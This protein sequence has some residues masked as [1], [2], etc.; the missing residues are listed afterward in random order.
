MANAGQA[1]HSI[2]SSSAIIALASFC[3]T[4][5]AMARFGRTRGRGV[6]AD[7]ESSER[8]ILFSVGPFAGLLRVDSGGLHP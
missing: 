4:Q 1:R 2:A 7:L 8:R 6:R 3:L 5:P